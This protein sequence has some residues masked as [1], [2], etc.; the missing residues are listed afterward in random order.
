MLAQV[1][2]G[3]QEIIALRHGYSGRSMLAQSLTAHV[4][5]ARRADADRRRSSTP[6]RPTATAVRSD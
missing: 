6:S 4:D 1:S 5:L 3:A 2:T